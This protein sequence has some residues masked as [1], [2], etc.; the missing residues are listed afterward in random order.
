ML[1]STA[2]IAEKIVKVD[3]RKVGPRLGKKVQTLIQDGKTGKFKLLE[4]GQVEIA[5]EILEKED[6]TTAF[7]CEEG[8]EADSTPQVVVLLETEIT[9][10]L[11]LEG[12]SRELI[13]AIQELRK[14]SGLEVSDRI[15][16][17]YQ[18]DSEK[19]RSMMKESSD[20]IAREVLATDVQVG[21]EAPLSV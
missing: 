8:L 9:P 10:E 21:P 20:H 11:E 3:A 6:Y 2:G 17:T 18:T 13:R 4:N 15:T 16:L 14:N 12:L 19:L 1:T 5:G 7:V